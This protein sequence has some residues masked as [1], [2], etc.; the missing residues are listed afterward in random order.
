MCGRVEIPVRVRW[1]QGEDMFAQS[2]QFLPEQIELLLLTDQ[3]IVQRGNGVFLKRRAHFQFSDAGVV[4]RWLRQ[5]SDGVTHI[6]ACLGLAVFA[7]LHLPDW[8]P[9]TMSSAC[10]DSCS[11]IQRLSIPLQRHCGDQGRKQ[12]ERPDVGGNIG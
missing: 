5:E 7:F 2:G 6:V 3:R 1:L 8:C 9:G 11:V 10:G 4:H 12:Q